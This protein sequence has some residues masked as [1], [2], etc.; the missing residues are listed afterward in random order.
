MSGSG[1]EYLAKVQGRSISG[2]FGSIQDDLDA[3]VAAAEAND[4]SGENTRRSAARAER[5]AELN[6]R[7]G[8]TID[9]V[10]G[11][12]RDTSN[13]LS[14]IHD[15]RTR[16]DVGRAAVRALG[17][18]VNAVAPGLGSM[19]T[20]AVEALW[21]GAS[22]AVAALSDYLHNLQSSGNEVAVNKFLHLGG[23]ATGTV[24]RQIEENGLARAYADGWIIYTFPSY[25]TRSIQSGYIDSYFSKYFFWDRFTSRRLKS[26]TSGAMIYAAGAGTI[27]LVAQDLDKRVVREVTNIPASDPELTKWWSLMRK[28]YPGAEARINAIFGADFSRTLEVGYYPGIPL[29]R[30]PKPTADVVKAANAVVMWGVDVTDIGTLLMGPGRR[31]VVAFKASAMPEE[32]FDAVVLNLLEEDDEKILD[33]FGVR[34]VL[35]YARGN[36]TWLPQAGALATKILEISAGAARPAWFRPAVARGTVPSPGLGPVPVVAGLGVLGLAL[37]LALK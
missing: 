1:W 5:L 16:E 36:R 13:L 3:A 10:G 29:T 26:G 30:E 2:S 22:R 35:G 18:A 34:W 25:P 4:P 9:E 20:A 17:L 11:V 12:L 14:T 23:Y 37:W 32:M 33:D 27:D 15:A 6:D 28:V 21:L 8:S 24:G 31:N 19:M 7:Y